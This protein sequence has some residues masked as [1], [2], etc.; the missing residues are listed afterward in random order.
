MG[1]S[2]SLGASSRCLHDPRLACLL[3]AGWGPVSVLSRTSGFL[4]VRGPRRARASAQVIS[5]SGFVFGINARA[6]EDI[7]N[8]FTV[9]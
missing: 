2:F 1:Q 9:I 3:A 6:R 7:L 4:S 5:S 8:P